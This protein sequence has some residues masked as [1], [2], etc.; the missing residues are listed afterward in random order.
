MPACLPA[1]LP[2]YVAT[3]ARGKI[4]LTAFNDCESLGRIGIGN[5]SERLVAQRILY[6][7]VFRLIMAS[8]DLDRFAA[9]PNKAGLVPQP[10]Y[11]ILNLGL[12]S[13]RTF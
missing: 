9:S 10:L 4:R 6:L 1:C 7:W 12:G 5:M 3:D 11:A 2:A 13:S 8:T